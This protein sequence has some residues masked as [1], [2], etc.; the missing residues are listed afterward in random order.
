MHGIARYLPFVLAVGFIGLLL[1][2][3]GLRFRRRFGCSPFRFP[4]WNDLSPGAWLSR[5]LVVILC[6]ILVLAGMAAF[7]PTE[8]AQL[9][10]LFRPHAF[11]L[12]AGSILM[13][14]GGALVWR[15]QEDM[16]DAW[17]VGIDPRER[18]PLVKR[19]LFLFCRN[20]IY[21]GLQ[22]AL[23][24]FAGMVPGLFSLAL[25]G[26]SLLLLQ[27]QA[28]LEEAHLLSQHGADYAEYCSS[29]GRFL[30]WTGRITPAESRD[31]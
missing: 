6:G 30:P 27:V 31:A 25:L 1:G 23:L 4:A 28:R 24:G 13:L 20:P 2:V 12:I 9:D 7:M 29:I 14:L 11:L 22:V 16:H 17:R 18:T 15:G 26:L 5:M 10:P 3:R 21:L 19:G 8:M